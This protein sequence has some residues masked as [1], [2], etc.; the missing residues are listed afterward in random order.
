MSRVAEAQGRAYSSETLQR[1]HQETHPNSGVSGGG[2][3]EGAGTG[4]KYKRQWCAV[5]NRCCISVQNI[6]FDVKRVNV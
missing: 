1:H 2:G 4:Y 3:V 5:T 6:K